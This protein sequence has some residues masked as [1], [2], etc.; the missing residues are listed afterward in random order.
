M[1]S[2]DRRPHRADRP[3]L[4][5]SRGNLDIVACRRILALGTHFVK[6]KAHCLGNDVHAV[7][8]MLLETIGALLF[9][10]PHRLAEPHDLE[11]HFG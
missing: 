1:H 3:G 5:R 10:W 8:E 11:Q 4:D 2:G 6:A 9:V 7:A